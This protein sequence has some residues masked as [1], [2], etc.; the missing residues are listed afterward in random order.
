[1][2]TAVDLNANFDIITNWEYDFDSHANGF[3]EA[4]VFELCNSVMKKLIAQSVQPANET[5]KTN[6]NTALVWLLTYKSC[7][8]INE[9]LDCLTVDAK[10]KFLGSIYAAPVTAGINDTQAKQIADLQA[11]LKD[12]ESQANQIDVLEGQIKKIN[13]QNTLRNQRQNNPVNKN[14]LRVRSESFNNPR[15]R[16][17]SPPPEPFR[18]ELQDDSFNFNS[19]QLNNPNNG[20]NT[21]PPQAPLHA[22]HLN[23]SNFQFD[24]VKD[25]NPK[26]DV[27]E[28]IAALTK[29]CTE[30]MRDRASGFN[31]NNPQ[32]PP[33]S[34]RKGPISVSTIEKWNSAKH[35][36][37]REYV[38]NIYSMWAR[39]QQITEE[40]STMFFSYAFDQQIHRSHI[41][42]LVKNENGGPRY[43]TLSPLIDQIIYDLKLNQETKDEIQMKFRSFKV[44][45]KRS[46]DEEFLRCFQLRRLGWDTESH[47]I[48]VSHCKIKFVKKLD[49]KS[50]LHSYVTNL[51]MFDAWSDCT[52]YYEI[53]IQLRDIEN[54]YHGHKS[55]VGSQYNQPTKMDCNAIACVPCLAQ[56]HVSNDQN[57]DHSNQNF[58]NI[59]S[60]NC[61]NPSCK[62]P[63]QPSKPKFVCCNMDCFK[64]WRESE[65]KP[66]TSFR[67]KKVNNVTNQTPN[68]NMPVSVPP[69]AQPPQPTPP[70]NFNNI[71]SATTQNL[72][73]IQNAAIAQHLSANNVSS[74]D[75]VYITPAHLFSPNCDVPFVAHNSLYDTGA[76]PTLMT[77]DCMKQANLGHLLTIPGNNDTFFGGDSE[78]MVGFRGF[79]TIDMAIQDSI[80]Y[81]TN[82]FRKRI[83]VF[84]KLNHD[85]IVGHDSMKIGTRWANQYPTLNKI[86]INATI[87]MTR[88]F[89]QMVVDQE[90]QRARINAVS[91]EG[92]LSQ[93]QMFSES[94]T[95]F[96]NIPNS[97]FNNV[98]L[99]RYEPLIQRFTK[100]FMEVAENY[101]AQQQ[102]INAVN[103]VSD[104]YGT[105]PEFD[106]DSPLANVLTEG[107]LDGMIDHRN[108]RVSD[109]KDLKTSKG[110]VVVG[111]QL[112]DKMTTTFKNFVDN[113]KGDIFDN[114]TLGKTKQ[115]C[116]PEVKADAKPHSTTSKY[117]PLNTFM[118]SEAATLVQKMVDL[119]V[120]IECTDTANSTIF[121]VQKSSGKWRLICDLRRYNERL[122]DFVVHLPSPWELINKICQ[123][124]LFSYVDFPEAYF[125]VPMS[126]ESIKSNPIVASVSG[127]Q[128][129]Y[130]FLR[131]AQGLRPATAMF[132]NIL[133]EIYASVQDF[134]FNYLDDSVV[135]SSNDEEVHF[136]KL[137]KF[138]ELTQNA[139]LKLSLKKSVFFAKDLTFLNYTVANK[140]WSLSNNQRATINALN[141]DNLTLKK[142]ESLAAFIQHFNKFHTGVAFASRKIRDPATS[143]DAVKCILDNIKRKLCSSP[144][145]RSVNFKDD[146][147]IY[148]DAS[149]FDCSG[150]ILQKT[151]NGFELV[152]CFSRKFPD[153][154]VNKNIYEKELWVLHQVTKT[155]RYLFLG[156]HKKVFNQDNAAVL[157]AQKSKAPSLNCLFNTIESTFSNVVFKFTPTSKNASDCFTRVGTVNNISQPWFNNIA[158][159]P[160][161]ADKILKVHCNAGCAPA[162]RI[163]TTIQGLPEYSL[164]TKKDVEEVLKRC[165]SCNMI[166]N[167]R[168]PRKSSPGI[169]VAKE[170]TCQETVFIDHKMIINKA[171]IN[172]I[173]DSNPDEIISNK[174][175]CLTV[176]E[177][178][179][180]LVWFFPVKSY[181]S[182]NV[183]EA[184]RSYIM[185]NGPPANVV[186]DNAL[187]FVSLGNWLEKEY[188]TKLHCTSAYH[189]NSNLS[190][191]S[192]LEFEKVIKVY[193]AET[194]AYKFE[195]WQ[196]ALSRACVTTNSLRHQLHKMSPYE[197]FKNRIQCDID[198]VKFHPIGLEHRVN[199]ERFKEKVEKIVNSRLK[200]ILPVYSKGDAVKVIFPKQQPR[201]GTVTSTADHKFKMAVKV[202]FDHDRPVSVSKNFICV[203]RNG[204]VGPESPPATVPQVLVQPTE[205]VI[206]PSQPIVPEYPTESEPN[207]FVEFP[208]VVNQPVNSQA[209]P[210]P[211]VATPDARTQRR[212]RRNTIMP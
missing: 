200:V 143:P 83:L 67:K 9:F 144:A 81:I 72:N 169:T 181:S 128:K 203:P 138:I 116:H 190:E 126:D 55:S 79:I 95:F 185:I 121:I 6:I 103:S 2:T 150:V 191:R 197:I 148:T 27:S 58:N 56:Q 29:L 64:A 115:V 151:K 53:S 140:A 8:T 107:G 155:F 183:K 167:F 117:M 142:R 118:K 164:I 137:K 146:L 210:E 51:S 124:E 87:R 109:T 161:F 49:M 119:G 162:E 93:P 60:K 42:Y 36:S 28:Q 47:A 62:K 61:K 129:N 80:G 38:D 37:L 212:N 13:H 199:L 15:S 4:K 166:E 159:P 96:L 91:S 123:F 194:K 34:S 192:H 105:T 141:T 44:C 158:M 14:V 153:A 21:P 50:L 71:S 52:S 154:V 76:S 114:T 104:S 19:S 106:K 7:F 156:P 66:Y 127:Q 135:G 176:F 182:E 17:N 112:S 11:R 88:K 204:V 113:Y 99:A 30:M 10:T 82:K 1:M 168:L 157:A 68:S 175:S 211:V 65:G 177:P 172:E 89:N 69:A 57:T 40:E 134:V 78:P 32:P 73:N 5:D 74:N 130:K 189:P 165:P 102:K 110:T 195:N 98:A 184:L 205:N 54:R 125:N 33:S 193:D 22:P 207:P 180:K 108:I 149:Q 152:A 86:L 178:V 201:F 209:P 111:G 84:N 196:D 188:K 94:S 26:T 35:G 85:F 179:S 160:S 18:P 90:K 100:N 139:G 45:G 198:P 39:A 147:H 170:I 75:P 174:Q 70:Q 136:S 132:V 171:R 145:L 59:S 48:C 31:N 23:N 41:N 12:F 46:L 63:F 208:V 20:A 206:P 202:K 163:L 101:D 120:L 186:S 122:S 92:D 173:R 77:F 24:E 25:F 97:T 187:S 43:K 133:N 3:V 131:M 16:F